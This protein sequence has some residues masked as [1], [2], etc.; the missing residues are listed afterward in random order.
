MKA[1]WNALLT[2]I[3]KL[4][5]YV[6]IVIPLKAQEIARSASSQLSWALLGDLHKQMVLWAVFAAVTATTASMIYIMAGLLILLL[7]GS[8]ALN[9]TYL[10]V[11]AG[12][13]LL[14]AIGVASLKMAQWADRLLE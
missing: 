9:V 14:A 13:V 1:I 3:M 7:K 8:L 12:S 4:V 11:W 10:I 5:I 2:A 6:L